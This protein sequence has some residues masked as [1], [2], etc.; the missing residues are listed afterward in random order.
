MQ[1]KLS[2][3]S[4]RV[5]L[6]VAALAAICACG[7][8][9]PDVQTADTVAAGPSDVTA[10][11]RKKPP[12]SP[13]EPAPTEPAPTEPAPTPTPTDPVPAPAPVTP[14]D[15]TTTASRSGLGMNLGRPTYY[16]SDWS[17][18]NEFKRA[19]GWAT[20]C[21]P[22][23][24]QAN[25]NNF[26]TG[27]NAGNTGESA[28]VNWDAN[29]YPLS[30]PAFSDPSV[31]Y[32]YLS[33]LL[34]QGDGGSHPVGK[35]VVLYDG[36]GRLEYSN[37]RKVDAESKPG[38]DIVDVSNQQFSLLLTAT[39][40][41]NHLRNIRVIAPGGACA[42]AAYTYVPDATRC[43]AGDFKSLEAL[44]ATQTYHPSYIGDLRGFRVLR[45]MN[46]VDAN[47]GKGLV[48]WSQRSQ[49]GDAMWNRD[50]GVPYEA[51]FDLFRETGTDAWVNTPVYVSDDFVLQLARLAKSKLAPGAR[52]YFE[53]GN[54]PWNQAPPYSEAG[55]HFEAQ[56]RLKW[57]GSTVEMW[58]QR[59]QWYAYRSV[60][61]CRII[62][63]EFG[64]E[65][66]RV[67]C[68]LNSQAANTFVS[69]VMLQCT[70]A[71][72]E[73][74]GA[75]GRQVD[76]LAIAPY[77]GY[78]FGDS[79][80][81]TKVEGWTTSEADG[82]VSRMFEEITGLDAAANPV[83]APLWVSGGWTPKDGALNES[84]RWMISTKAL[85]DTYGLPMIAYEGGQHLQTY[86]GGA[87]EA[88]FA[89]VNRDPRMGAALTR[90][91][92]DWKAAGGQLYVPF[93]YVSGYGVFGFW[94]MK[95]SQLDD[96]AA[97]WIA[98]RQYRDTG[99]WWTGCSTR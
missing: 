49:P 2:L 66:G 25:C 26:A 98:T 82:G 24:G 96:N 86:R 68:L 7:G 90:H 45:T 31:K 55:V 85:A 35:Y 19:G 15:T 95:E 53:Y 97:K 47:A 71:Q 23:I 60:Q 58:Q 76:A 43:T 74:G 21:N 92:D 59:L 34:F 50:S 72:A 5:V 51:I 9:S 13:T 32:R 73:L 91:F 22:W 89:K 93:T 70:L 77:F 10:L 54:E 48:D 75:C 38:R 8:G 56:A 12:T 79:S 29:G 84:K 40:P 17:Y 20:S 81:V 69:Q 11:A 46:W 80:V 65:A 41:A 27:T 30:L 52:F 33:A 44:S 61:L 1:L 94:G 3:R 67:T 4:A 37:A 28:L 39:N 18:I 57:P 63:A 83:V 62:K 42:S 36:E 78:Y 87:V 6:G 88:L 14:P 64:T 99:C 16:S